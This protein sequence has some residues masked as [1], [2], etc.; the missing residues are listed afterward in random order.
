MPPDVSIVVVARDRAALTLRCLTSLARLPD[1]PT[2]EVILIDDGSSDD[3]PAILEAIE[4]DLVTLRNDEP[5][6][7]AAACDRAVAAAGG[8]HVVVLD[9]DA[10]PCDGW[11]TALTAT[12]TG[13][14]GLGA[15]APRSI[16]LAG[17]FLP[18]E[19]WLALAVRRAAYE[20]VGGFAGTAK[21]GQAEK[22]ALLDGLRAAGWGVAEQPDAIL[23][24]VPD[25]LAAV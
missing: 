25:T 13:D 6:G 5:A 1:E 20:E 21:A 12:F 10:V 23:L 3:T 11:L 8:E 24:L 9:D 15:V 16:D 22:T 19:D 14:P 7:F 2:F 18:Q 17:A 4:G